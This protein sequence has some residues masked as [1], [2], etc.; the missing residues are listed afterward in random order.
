MSPSSISVYSRLF[1]RLIGRR[2]GGK[3]TRNDRRRGDGERRREGGLERARGQERKELIMER[4]TKGIEE[5]E[6]RTY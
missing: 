3:E 2:T 5:R 6:D 4:K 1:K